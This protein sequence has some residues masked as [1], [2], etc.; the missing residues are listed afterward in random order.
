MQLETTEPT[1]DTI[2]QSIKS[3][4]A[5]AEFSP[6]CLVISL[7]YIERLRSLSDAVAICERRTTLLRPESRM[8]TKCDG[9]SSGSASASP[10]ASAAASKT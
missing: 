9:G 5:I 2:F 4:Y 7:L 3:I 8:Y 1:E 6:E 10:R